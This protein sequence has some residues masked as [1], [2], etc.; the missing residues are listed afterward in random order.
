MGLHY[1]DLARLRSSVCSQT[2]T[3]MG[4]HRRPVQSMYWGTDARL[5]ACIPSVSLKSV[6]CI[7]LDALTFFFF[8][9]LRHTFAYRL[10]KRDLWYDWVGFH[11]INNHVN[12]SQTVEASLECLYMDASC[13]A[14]AV[15]RGWKAWYELEQKWNQ[16]TKSSDLNVSHRDLWSNANVTREEK[17]CYKITHQWHFSASQ[18]KLLPNSKVAHTGQQLM[19][20]CL[21]LHNPVWHLHSCGPRQTI[22]GQV[23]ATS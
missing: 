17:N 3:T 2:Q 19:S 16:Q 22:W 21:I 20:Q 23:A 6:F 10:F 4:C 15:D 5:P 13:T 8:F 9:I 7:E 11:C 14:G 12:Q 18:D 1:R